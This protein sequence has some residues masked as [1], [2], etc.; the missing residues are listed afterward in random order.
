LES[1][2]IEVN[3]RLF[4]ILCIGPTVRTHMSVFRRGPDLIRWTV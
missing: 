1:V 4:H 2:S 3:A